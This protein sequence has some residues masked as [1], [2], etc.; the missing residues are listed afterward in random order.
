MLRFSQRAGSRTDTFTSRFPTPLAM[1]ASVPKRSHAPSTRNHFEDGVRRLSITHNSTAIIGFSDAE[2]TGLGNYIRG[3][4]IEGQSAIRSVEAYG[5]RTGS[6][7]RGRPPLPGS[8]L[9]V[10][11]TINSEVANSPAKLAAVRAQLAE[12]ESAA[13][14]GKAFPIRIQSEIDVVAPAV[15]AQLKETPFIPMGGNH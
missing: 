5:S 3:V 7:F 2:A 12:I 10:F 8:D 6:T 9:D 15:K 11:V 13:S 4:N 14:A 1:D